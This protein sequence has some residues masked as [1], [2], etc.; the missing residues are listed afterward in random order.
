MFL[1]NKRKAGDD[2]MNATI[3]RIWQFSVKN[4]RRRGYEVA[5]EARIA[6]LLSAVM[7]LSMPGGLELTAAA[8]EAVQETT[9]KRN[10]EYD[11]VMDT[12]GQTIVGYTGEPV[13]LVIP[14]GTV[15]IGTAL[16]SVQF[17]DSLEEIG[18]QAFTGCTTLSSVKFG[19]G[20]KAI[21]GEACSYC[22]SL[23]SLTLPYWI[24]DLYMRKQLTC[25]ASG[26]GG[27]PSTRWC[28]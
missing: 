9:S 26:M 24:L 10:S 1:G 6:A 14:E 19:S 2:I 3:E 13:N 8:T 21:G 15:A 18:I 23:K 16:A 11:L 12:S 25:T 22:T 28:W 27:L 7:L 17:P 4:K 20:L 5:L